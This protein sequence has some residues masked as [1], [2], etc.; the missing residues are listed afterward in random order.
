MNLNRGLRT[1]IIS[2]LILV[3]WNNRGGMINSYLVSREESNPM[4]SAPRVKIITDSTADLSADQAR[5]FG[6][7]V[8]PVYVRFGNQVYRD[9]VDLSPDAF[10]RKMESSPDYPYTSQPSPEDFTAAYN[11]ACRDGTE[12]VSIHVSSKLS[13]TFN[14]ALLACNM[15]AGRCRVE[16]IDSQFNSGGLALVV[17]AAARA[18]RQGAGLEAVVVE[19]RRAIGQVSMLGIFTSVKYLSYSGRVNRAVVQ[20]AR[21]LSIKPM[22][23]FHNGEIARAGFVRTVAQGLDRLAGFVKSRPGAVQLAVVHGEMSGQAAEL[24]RRLEAL[25]PGVEVMMS[26]LGPALG[27]HGGPGTLVVAVQTVGPLV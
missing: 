13:G 9:G 16:V 26:R 8:V 4:D 11:D 19:A 1:L 18:A 2:H 6:V 23:T 5:E 27:A 7:T 10:Y 15:L 21:I 22:L 17:K 25:C 3:N 14:S 24:K 12:I 20:A